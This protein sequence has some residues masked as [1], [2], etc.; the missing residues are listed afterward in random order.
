MKYYPL[1]I[2]FYMLVLV[3]FAVVIP[4][5]I[6]EAG[7]RILYGIKYLFSKKGE[8]LSYGVSF[9]KSTYNISLLLSTVEVRLFTPINFTVLNLM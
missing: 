3:P 7:I 2:V 4:I 5:I 8:S 9:S 1:L 6:L